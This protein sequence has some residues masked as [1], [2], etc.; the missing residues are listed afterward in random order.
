MAPSSHGRPSRLVRTWLGESRYHE[1]LGIAERRN[2]ER[3]KTLALES[4]L[5]H[6]ASLRIVL[7]GRYE[8]TA[9]V[10]ACVVRA[11]GPNASH[12]IC[13]TWSHTCASSGTLASGPR[14]ERRTRER[15][16]LIVLDAALELVTAGER[17][18]AHTSRRARGSTLRRSSAPARPTRLRHASLM[19]AV[20]LRED[21]GA[22]HDIAPSRPNSSHVVSWAPTEPS[23]FS[24]DGLHAPHS[25]PC[26][27]VPFRL[28]R[29]T[30]DRRCDDANQ[31]RRR[32]A[33]DCATALT[34]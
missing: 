3:S 34:V 6:D 2:H 32:G 10:G 20:E 23:H 12:A 18:L 30:E 22:A 19:C 8:R 13:R 5:E 21:V 1:P 25:S 14:V 16:Q 24:D 33:L 15:F 17:T 31:F 29:E 4:A 9:K 26:A 11:A 7:V 28:A 27:V